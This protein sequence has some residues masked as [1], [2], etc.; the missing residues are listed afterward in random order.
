M[1]T[2]DETSRLAGHAFQS[3]LAETSVETALNIPTGGASAHV[4]VLN[5]EGQIIGRVRGLPTEQ[6]VSQVKS[7]VRSAK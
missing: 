4:L 6:R 5:S 2:V 7:T 3:L 1:E